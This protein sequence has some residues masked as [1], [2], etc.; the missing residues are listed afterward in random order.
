MYHFAQ[1]IFV[2]KF[3][4]TFGQQNEGGGVIYHN[5]YGCE[6]YPNQMKYKSIRFFQNSI[7]YI[8]FMS[9]MSQAKPN[10]MPFSIS[11]KVNYKITILIGICIDH[12]VHFMVKIKLYKFN[13][14]K[15]KSWLDPKNEIWKNEFWNG[16][17]IQGL[18]FQYIVTGWYK[19]E[20]ERERKHWLVSRTVAFTVYP[21]WSRSFTSH[22]AMYPEAPVTHTTF[23]SLL[24]FSL[25]L[26]LSLWSCVW[27][28]KL[29]LCFVWVGDFLVWS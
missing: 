14:K 26:S 9:G 7:T 19:L 23:S 27:S 16:Y 5:L 6:T 10:Y 12:F 3:L 18:Y 4:L 24:I 17:T 11:P 1:W 21:R 20:R 22:A 29:W 13:P 28:E 15:I 25:S 8:N 2:E